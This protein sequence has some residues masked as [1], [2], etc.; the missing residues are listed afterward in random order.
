MY[1]LILRRKDD[2]VIFEEEIENI[3]LLRKRVNK[4]IHGKSLEILGK[5]KLY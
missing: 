1:K 4:I 5:V 3:F 2:G